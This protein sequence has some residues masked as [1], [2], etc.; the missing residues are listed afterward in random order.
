MII[1]THTYI[2]L[3][4]QIESQQMRTLVLSIHTFPRPQLGGFTTSFPTQKSGRVS[5]KPRRKSL[6][7]YIHFIQ[8][9]RDEMHMPCYALLKENHIS[10]SENSHA[11]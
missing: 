3:G 8:V 1:Q 5:I 11:Q 9:S 4:L 2:A 7:K 6:T 10:I